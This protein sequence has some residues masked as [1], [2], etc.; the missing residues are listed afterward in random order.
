MFGGINLLRLFDG[1][2]IQPQYDVMV[3]IEFWSSHGDGLI[4]VMGEDGEGA[5]SIKTNATDGGRVNVLL[6]KDTLDRSAD[7]T[8]DI[9]G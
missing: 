8:P 4:S 3:I 6:V 1:P 2:M 5:G 9:V 7:T